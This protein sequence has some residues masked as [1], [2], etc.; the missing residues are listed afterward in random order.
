MGRVFDDIAV[1]KL[2]TFQ[3][4]TLDRTDFERRP[5]VYS[6]LSEYSCSERFVWEELVELLLPAENFTIHAPLLRLSRVYLYHAIAVIF[7]SRTFFIC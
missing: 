5:L 6:I 3:I 4:P 7:G 1:W 2:L